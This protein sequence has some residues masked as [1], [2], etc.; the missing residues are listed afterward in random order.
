MPQLHSFRGAKTNEMRGAGG[1]VGR[2]NQE[3]GK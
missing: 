3:E 2:E 1:E